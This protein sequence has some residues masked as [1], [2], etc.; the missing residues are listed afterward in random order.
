M[1]V[2]N[3]AFDSLTP[4]LPPERWWGN[5]LGEARWQL[6][7]SRLM[8][9]PVFRGV[10]VPRGDGAPVVLI[11]GFLAGDASLRIMRAWL[12]RVGY[13]SHASGI[14]V[15]IDCSDR[16]VDAL[17]RRLER[18]SALA[19]RKVALIGHSRGGHFVKALS[20]RRPE[21][22]SS[23]ISMGAGLDTPFDISAPTR[24]AVAAVRAVHALTSDRLARNGCFTATCNCRFRRDYQ[25]VFPDEVPLTSIYSRGDGV[26]RWRACLVPYARCVEV[27]GSHIG[28]PFN[29]KVYQE[30]A[31]TLAAETTDA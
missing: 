5:H 22:I 19:E 29:R 6:E 14:S 4:A 26:V 27:T 7:L 12:R 11:P 31:W 24:G 15:N 20:R 18:I 13:V 3:L 30:V 1:Q 17:E 8:V 21:L 25:D 16:A 2:A 9:D 28:L 23:A 10:G